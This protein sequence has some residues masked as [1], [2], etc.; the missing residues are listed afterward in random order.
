MG[1]PGRG[2]GRGGGE[3]EMMLVIIARGGS[4]VSPLYLPYLHS[5]NSTKYQGRAV[6]GTAC[7]PSRHYAEAR[8]HHSCLSSLSVAMA[9]RGLQTYRVEI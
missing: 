8:Q 2:G 4:L 7:A 9:V 6:C 5:C 3:M 1:G